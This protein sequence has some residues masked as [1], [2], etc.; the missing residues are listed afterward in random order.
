MQDVQSFATRRPAGSSQP[1]FQL[2]PP[3]LSRLSRYQGSASWDT[4]QRIPAAGSS[5]LTPSFSMSSGRL[6][7]ESSSMNRESS[8]SSTAGNPPYVPMGLQSYPSPSFS[9]QQMPHQ[10]DQ[11]G[12]RRGTFD[13]SSSRL[14]GW[15][16]PIMS[17]LHSPGGQMSIASG[18]SMQ[19]RPSQTGGP[20]YEH[21]LIQ[22]RQQS[23]RPFKCDQCLQGFNRNFDLKRHMRIHLAVKPFPCGYCE[24]SFSRKDALKVRPP[25]TPIESTVLST[26]LE[27]SYEN[28][29]IS[30]SKAAGKL[31]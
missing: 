10:L 20:A 17:N 31:R 18:M 1:T 24:K 27:L 8:G 4:T 28:R 26:E 13:H 22:Q 6:D 29:G 12:L 23:D 5:S 3:D 16:R 19:Y 2:P 30:S 21:H 25:E 11:P 14:Y 7:P 15:N 9:T